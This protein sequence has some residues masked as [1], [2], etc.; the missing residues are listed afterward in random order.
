MVR[1]SSHLSALE[2]EATSQWAHL[3]SFLVDLLCILAGHILWDL[4]VFVF[5]CDSA[6]VGHYFAFRTLFFTKMFGK[7]GT[8]PYILGGWRY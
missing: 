1:P 5:G 2:L 7:Y 8:S 6:Q 4:V 3:L